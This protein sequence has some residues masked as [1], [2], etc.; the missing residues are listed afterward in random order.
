MLDSL[1]HA[2]RLGGHSFDPTPSP[3]L[4]TVPQTETNRLGMHHCKQNPRPGLELTL[5]PDLQHNLCILCQDNRL[6]TAPISADNPPKRVL[7]AGCGTG[8]WAIEFGESPSCSHSLLR[9]SLTLTVASRPIPRVCR[10]RCRLEPNPARLVS[11]PLVPP[12]KDCILTVSSVPPNVEFFVDDLEEDWTYQTHFDFIYMRLLTGS[13]L[14]WPKLFGQA[15]QY[16][17]HPLL[18]YTR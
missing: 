13:I 16:V 4:L 6:F 8:I 12:C 11:L 1:F 2:K 18:W 9:L 7:D 14:N 5:S 17:L 10:C 15:F 3:G